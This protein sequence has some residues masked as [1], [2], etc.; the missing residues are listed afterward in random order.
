MG[1]KIH[2]KQ[3]KTAWKSVRCFPL[4][5][6]SSP[7]STGAGKAWYL[8][9]QQQTDAK[10]GGGGCLLEQRT[11]VRRRCI[12]NVAIRPQIHNLV[13]KRWAGGKQ[14]EEPQ[15]AWVTSTNEQSWAVKDAFERNVER[16]KISVVYCGSFNKTLNY[17]KEC[18]NFIKG[19][20]QSTILFC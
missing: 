18:D 16:E 8:G 14:T 9:I 4:H 17:G 5:L 12:G 10:Q 3:L 7:R 2:N 13:G 11:E 15:N 19:N 6:Q 1:G 20:K